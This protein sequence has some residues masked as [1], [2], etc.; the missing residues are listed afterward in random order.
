MTLK[1]FSKEEWGILANALPKKS[2][3]KKDEI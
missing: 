1:E 3:I 2:E